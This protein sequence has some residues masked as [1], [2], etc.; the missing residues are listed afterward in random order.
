MSDRPQKS[1]IRD[2]ESDIASLARETEMPIATVR[3]IWKVEHAK[4]EVVAKIKTYVPVLVRRRVRDLLR[5]P[6]IQQR[7]AVAARQARTVMSFAA[8]WSPRVALR[9]VRS[10]MVTP[11]TFVAAVAKPNL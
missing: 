8:W 1:Q 9:A 3:E 10:T 11:T 4:L 7:N 5:S 6:E 2:Q